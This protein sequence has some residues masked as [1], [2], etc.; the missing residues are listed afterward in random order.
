LL[1]MI[2]A[3]YGLFALTVLLRMRTELLITYRQS[4][5]LRSELS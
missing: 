4:A 2:V 1:L 5:W 3:F